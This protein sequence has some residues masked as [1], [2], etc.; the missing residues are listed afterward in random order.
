[1]ILLPGFKSSTVVI[2][3]FLSND[4]ESLG[5]SEWVER[6]EKFFTCALDSIVI[7]DTVCAI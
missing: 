1:M 5:S 3:V 6:I 4:D 2:L 7:F